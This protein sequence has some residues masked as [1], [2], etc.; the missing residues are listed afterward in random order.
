MERND[1]RRAKSKRKDRA[2]APRLP[3]YSNLTTREKSAYERTAKLVSE[4]R[5][6]KGAY[7]ELLRRY[8]LNTRTARKHAGRSLL[9]G[10][11]GRRVRASKSDSLVRELFFPTGWGDVLRP[12]R[13]SKAASK[14]SDYYNDREKLLGKELSPAEFEAKWRGIRIAG[15]ELFANADRIFQMEEADVLKIDDLYGS[16]GSA[17]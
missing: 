15:R 16:V 13:G 6:G 4:L 10:E 5:R 14:L 2:V 8:H 7:T 9:G 3:K 12:V 17:E 1:R 11:R